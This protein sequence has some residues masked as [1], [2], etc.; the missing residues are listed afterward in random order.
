MCVCVQAVYQKPEEQAVGLLGGVE[1]P[2]LVPPASFQ[3]SVF[4]RNDSLTLT[5]MS[6]PKEFLLEIFL[7]FSK[8]KKK[9]NHANILIL[10]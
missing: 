6:P 2:F 1:N 4:P 7:N 5:L 9:G 10:E 3:L 8:K